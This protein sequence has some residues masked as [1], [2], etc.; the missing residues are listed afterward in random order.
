MKTPTTGTSVFLP[1]T[2]GATT[3]FDVGFV[4]D[5]AMFRDK[6]I[7]NN[8][9]AVARLT[10]QQKLRTNLTNAETTAGAIGWDAKTNFWSQNDTGGSV[11]NWIFKRA[12]SFF[13]VVCYT[14]TGANRTVTHNLGVVPELMIVANRSPGGEYWPVYAAPLGNTTECLLQ[15]TSASQSTVG[16]DE[17]WNSTTP[18]STVFSV[19]GDNRV[20][21][22]GSTYVAYLFASLTGVSKVGSYTGNGSNQTINCGFTGGARFVLIKRT[23]STGDWVVFDSARGIVAGNDPALELNTTDAEVTTIDAVDTDNSG[24]VVNQEGTLNLNVNS[25][26]YIFLSIA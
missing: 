16:G 12:P 23:D 17:A 2:A 14:G 3:A 15:L 19:S 4:P 26:S 6:S 10:G 24:F 21:A 7:T 22:S 5:F 20:N 25:A 1:S 9:N 18:T 11:I 13:D 8:T